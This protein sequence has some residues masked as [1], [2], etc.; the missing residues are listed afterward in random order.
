MASINKLF[1][2][3]S[4]FSTLI[5]LP[6]SSIISANFLTSNSIPPE[7]DYKGSEYLDCDQTFLVHWSIINAEETIYFELVAKTTGFVGFGISPK[8]GM[9][10]AD[11]VIAGVSSNHSTYV[12]V[13]IYNQV[14]QLILKSK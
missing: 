11:I 8:G 5:L 2:Q 13:R 4:L 1:V 6:A 14:K 10:G 12:F 9:T 3:I 7:A